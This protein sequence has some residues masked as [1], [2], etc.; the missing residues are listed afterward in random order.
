MREWRSRSARAW[1][2]QDL[3]SMQLNVA[4]QLGGR[5]IG[6]GED[7]VLELLLVGSEALV[8]L[9]EQYTGRF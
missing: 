4:D 2:P 7:E 5:A 8:R 9:G 6:G 1:F 3:C